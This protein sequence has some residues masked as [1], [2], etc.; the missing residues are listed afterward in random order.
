MKL[1]ENEQLDKYLYFTGKL[2][3]LWNK[4]VTVITMVLGALGIVTKDQGKSTNET[5][6]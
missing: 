5:G 4:K 3:T 1:K 2:I 6:G